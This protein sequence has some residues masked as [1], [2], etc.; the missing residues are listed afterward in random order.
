MRIRS[1]QNILS[2]TLRR[3]RLRFL[4]SLFLAI[5]LKNHRDLNAKSFGYV[6]DLKNSSFNVIKEFK[7]NLTRS[8]RNGKDNTKIK[9]C[10]WVADRR[11]TTSSILNNLILEE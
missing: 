10:R 7:T 6:P 5:S 8:Q 3:H 11:L 2:T 9:F 1:K 4:K